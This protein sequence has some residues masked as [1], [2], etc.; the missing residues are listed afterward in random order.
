TLIAG[1]SN[2][3]EAAETLPMLNHIMSFPTSI[4][5]D[6]KGRVRKIH[7]GFYG[8]GTGKYYDQFVEET[9]AFLTKLLAES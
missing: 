3:T 4:F 8:P 9:D 2:K 6:R 7:T 1:T 5:I